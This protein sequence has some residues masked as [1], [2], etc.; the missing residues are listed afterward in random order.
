MNGT[1]W[2]FWALLIL[3][4]ASA[5][6]TNIR[7]RKISKQLQRLTEILWEIHKTGRR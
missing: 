3:M 6:E 7:L 4:A 5:I 2:P 1:T